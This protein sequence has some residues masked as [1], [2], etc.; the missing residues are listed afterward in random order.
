MVVLIDSNIILDLLIDRLPFAAE[1]RDIFQ[2][3]SRRVVVGYLA[4][5]TI[6][7]VYY[8]LRKNFSAKQR[9]NLLLDLCAN[10]EIIGIDKS[11]L[12]AAL[13][14][15]RFT[16]FEDGLQ[17]ECAKRIGA[18]YIVTRNLADFIVSPV[19]AISPPDFLKIFTDDKIRVFNEGKFYE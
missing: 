12:V 5:H 14:D 18:E 15:E 8:I 3:C 2:L 7:A 19:P 10:V 16:D 11:E 9:R 6:P 13:T 17:A 1:A 4:G